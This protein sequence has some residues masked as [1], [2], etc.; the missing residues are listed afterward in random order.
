[1]TLKPM[2][3]TKSKP[4]QA[5]TPKLQND[6]KSRLERN[7]D[8][9][10]EISELIGIGPQGDELREQKDKSSAPSPTNPTPSPK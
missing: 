8:P 9:I 3:D 7:Y 4:Q 5:T 6:T 2:D 10:D 1:M